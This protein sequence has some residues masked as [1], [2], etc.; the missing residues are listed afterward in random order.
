LL[1]EV[2]ERSSSPKSDWDVSIEVQ[3]YL[4]DEQPEIAKV[5]DWVDP[6]SHDQD[7][8]VYLTYLPRWDGTRPV[9]AEISVQHHFGPI[10]T[11]KTA[12]L[13][14]LQRAVPSRS[15]ALNE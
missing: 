11:P 6:A 15:E 14:R 8:V 9:I 2:L 3:P 12:V 7:A 1:H 4:W 5:I 10:S 13:P